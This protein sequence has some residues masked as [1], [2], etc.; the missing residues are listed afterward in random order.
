MNAFPLSPESDRPVPLIRTFRELIEKQTCQTFADFEEL[1]RWSVDAPSEF[2]QAVWDFAEMESPT[3]A[4]RGLNDLPMPGTGWFPGA[5]VNYARQV[6][7]HVDPAHA[8][9]HPAIIAEDESRAIETALA[10]AVRKNCA[11]VLSGT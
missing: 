6:M 5:Q 3:R 8:A 1:H 7:R 11:R 10:D 9:G 4:T 2:W